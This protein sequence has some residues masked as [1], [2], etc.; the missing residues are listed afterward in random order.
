MVTRSNVVLEFSENVS[1]MDISF[2]S[3]ML[4]ELANEPP[5]TTFS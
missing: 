4:Q 3:A 1:V 2:V 5:L